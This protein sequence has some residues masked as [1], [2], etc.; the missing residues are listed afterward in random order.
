MSQTGTDQGYE[1]HWQWDGAAQR[2][3][4]H[5]VAQSSVADLKGTWSLDGVAPLLDGLS[6][7]R[8]Q[9]S[10]AGGEVSVNCALTLSDGRRIQLVGAFLNPD[11]AQ[12]MILSGA[13]ML[14]A[15]PHQ[16]GT[17]PELQPVFQ[18]IVAVS[19]T[20]RIMGFEALARWD[21]GADSPFASVRFEDE[22][23]ASNMILL[24][25]EALADWH[26]ATGRTDLFVHV[27]LTGRDLEHE[28]LV[29]LVQAVIEGYRLPRK[30]LRIELTEQAALRDAA[31]AL[32]VADALKQVGAG[33]VLDDFGTGHS[34]FTWL[35]DLPADG[36]KIDPGL[37]R[38][39]GEPRT[40]AIL[41]AVADLAHTLGMSIT[42]E[43]IE[44]QDQLDALRRFGFDYAQGFAF[45]RPLAR[46]VA[47]Q[48]LQ[49]L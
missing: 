18:P 11:Q 42:G 32:K 37:T 27:N 29:G 3:A 39:T 38:R 5:T 48:R 45:D 8:L 22:G 20:S 33:L 47:T 43:G 6:R 44:T 10:L 36:V 17:A 49:G 40:E 26:A 2:L 34:S 23:L 41:K 21:G 1:G 19:D 24:A 46:E 13:R 25:A 7:S 28:G 16:E 15:A 12:G 14:G 30:A 31:E 35:A 4:L 9:I